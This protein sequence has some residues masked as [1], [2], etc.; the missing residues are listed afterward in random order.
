MSRLHSYM[1]TSTAR[2]TGISNQDST[3]STSPLTEPVS[4]AFPHRIFVPEH[5]ESGYAYPL[6]VWLHSDHSSEFEIDQVMPALSVRNYA[7]VALRGNRLSDRSTRL[8]RWGS[9]STD[10]A[11][12]EECIF[13]A[14]EE[15]CEAMSIDASRVFLGGFGKGATLAQWVGLRNPGRI[16]GVIACNGPFPTN[17]RA[18]T[19]WKD[20]RSLP[21][22][23]MQSADSNRFGVDQLIGMMKTAH[24]AGL[25]YRLMRFS[26]KS[27]QTAPGALLESQ[28][29]DDGEYEGSL[30]VEML[31]A[32]N[33]FMMGIVTGTAISLGC[34]PQPLDHV[35]W[36]Q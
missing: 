1:T 10:Y 9:T 5:Y 3:C 20:A 27:Q 17:K 13:H 7:A 22:L 2:A 25:N 34:E 24:L 29:N 14:I 31:K 8:F 23:A 4:I 19:Q 30:E 12:N 35:P 26:S 11:L 21:V 33:R 36:P 32:A 28:R 6:L 15:L 18:L 16:A